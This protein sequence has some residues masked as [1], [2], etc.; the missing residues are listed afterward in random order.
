M[1][2]LQLNPNETGKLIL[3]IP[4]S[5]TIIPFYECFVLSKS[6]I[7]GEIIKLTDWHT[8]EIFD[9]ASDYK[10]VAPFS[11][12]FCDVERFT[13]DSKEIM[14]KYGMGV[15]YEKTDCGRQLRNVSEEIRKKI[16]NDYYYAHHNRFSKA[17]DEELAVSGKALIIDC[18]SFP[19]VPLKRDQ[20][21]EQNRPDICIGTDD[22]H[23]PV[24]LCEFTTDYFSSN[25][26]SFLVNKPYNGSI[27]PL[28]HYQINR[29]VMS[30]MIEIN[31]RLYLKEG[32][33]KSSGFMK[34]SKLISDYLDGIKK[35]II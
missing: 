27:V 33:E 9:S 17:V 5:S 26:F 11:R 2:K 12:L 32:S 1:K 13:D 3:H 10:I 31:R 21:Q 25:G 14:S 4:H 6:E 34:I 7:A 18:H 20:D 8:D 19:D 16:L 23:T 30:V 28:S 35:C 15:L 22:F 24:W 29:N